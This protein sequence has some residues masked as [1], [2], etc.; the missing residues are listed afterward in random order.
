MGRGKGEKYA[1]HMADLK[2]GTFF[3]PQEELVRGTNAGTAFCPFLLFFRYLERQVQ[4][5]R[6]TG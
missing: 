6:Q 1:A 4:V 3:S 2:E 5:S